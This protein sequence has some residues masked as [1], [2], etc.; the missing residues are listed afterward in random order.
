MQQN[1]E[2]A[3]SLLESQGAM[4]SEAMS[5]IKKLYQSY[6]ERHEHK[7]KP[8]S[9]EVSDADDSG[10]CR[11]VHS[12][13]QEGAKCRDSVPSRKFKPP[14]SKRQQLSDED[15]I[16]I[17]RLRPK[18]QKG[19]SPSR[20][21]MVLCKSIAPKYGVSAKTVRDI[22]RGR[23]WLHAT[24]H[25]WTEEEKQLLRVQKPAKAGRDDAA[26]QSEADS[27]DAMQSA[28]QSCV[29][30]TVPGP[31]YSLESMPSRPHLFQSIHSMPSCTPSILQHSLESIPHLPQPIQSVPLGMP[32]PTLQQLNLLSSWPPMGGLPLRS[33]PTPGPNQLNAAH[34]LPSSTPSFPP[35]GHADS[36]T[37]VSL[38]TASIPVGP[39]PLP[40]W[41]HRAPAE[42]FS[43]PA[44]VA[45]GLLRASA[46]VTQAAAGPWLAGIP[47]GPQLAGLQG[48]GMPGGRPNGG[49]GAALTRQ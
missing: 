1:F 2:T 49:W 25:L 9:K 18:H 28:A 21:S 46:T 37:A 3:L 40:P 17:F 19:H 30:W 33:P 32:C 42:P 6:Q 12:D 4:T 36:I 34:L 35:C 41:F 13:R 44:P 20:G 38:P 10:S 29:S 22:W 31:W 11:S 26:Q 43:P 39:F 45:A 8:D 15:A 23:T 14:S 7:S 48:L 16:E 24:E 47:S 5:Q 27:D